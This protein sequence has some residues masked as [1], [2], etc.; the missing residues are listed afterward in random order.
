MH[1]LLVPQHAYP[2]VSMG[3]DCAYRL[4]YVLILLHRG[5]SMVRLL[6]QAHEGGVLSAPQ[7]ISKGKY[8]IMNACLSFTIILTKTPSSTTSLGRLR[9]AARIDSGGISL[10]SKRGWAREI[11]TLYHIP[12]SSLKTQSCSRKYGTRVPNR[13][14]YSNQ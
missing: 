11:L 6:G 4:I 2:L 9:L 5:F 13:S 10:V 12:T 3:N 7:R 1:F 14:G 8:I